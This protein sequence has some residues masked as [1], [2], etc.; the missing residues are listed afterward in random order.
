MLK[1]VN[2]TKEFGGVKAV[3]DV[4]FDVEKGEIVSIIGPNGAGKTTLFNMLTGLIKPTKG[5]VI[6]QG[7][8]IIPEDKQSDIKK[9]NISSII[10]GIYSVLI[11]FYFF[12]VHYKDATFQFEYILF[13]ISVA[14]LRVFSTVRLYQ[15]VEWAR[16]FHSIMLFF[17]AAF[18]IYFAIVKGLI[19]PAVLIF[20]IAAYFYFYLMSKKT[21][22]LFGEFL[23]A[24]NITKMGIA[25]TFQNIRLF[26][27][28]TVLENILI[29]FHL[30]NKSH[31]GNIL[32]RTSAQK[33]EEEHLKK[34][35]E[36]L[37][38]Y[39]GIKHDYNTLASNL[40]YGEQRKLEIAR[41]LAIRPA[42]L[43]LDEPAAG[44][45]PKETQELLELIEK[46]RKNGITII[47]IEHDMKLVMNISDRI[48]VLD[49][50]EKIA[51]GLPE[52]IKNN[53][54]VIEAY[55]GASQD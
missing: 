12:L 33:A 15:R 22:Q 10:I 5:S 45:N 53:E 7:N 31:I 43:L 51:E 30:H 25:R 6:F 21:R 32:L 29:G 54:R 49:Y 3:S 9:L 11:M 17:D 26:Q 42:L 47:L 55:L 35:A 46:I 37:L 2:L 20:F 44:M 16:G 28:L 27:N 14:I 48:I 4:S 40:P 41:A 19:I 1:V 13:I 24:E 23:E 18:A 8:T 52:E 38:K 50:G 34:E 39:V 36:K